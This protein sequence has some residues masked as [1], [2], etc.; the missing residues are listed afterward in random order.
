[1]VTYSAYIG[2]RLFLQ[3]RIE[4]NKRQA[5]IFI[6]SNAGIEELADTLISAGIIKN[7]D[8]FRTHAAIH[9]FRTVMG[10]H[11]IVK[12]N[13][14]YRNLVRMLISGQQ[15]P[16]N[17]VISGTVRTKERLA[18]IISRQIEADSVE[19][20]DL[21]NDS[22]FLNELGFTPDNSIL[23][24]I[25]NTYNVYWNRNI[26]QLFRDMKKEFDRFWSPERLAKLNS[27]N[28]T[29]IEA[30]IVASISSEESN[31]YD[32]LPCIAGVYIN[33]LRIGMPLQAD[34]TVKFA[35][36]D[37]SLRRILTVHTEFDSPYNTYRHRGLPPGPI[38]IPSP[39]AIDAVLDCERHN[40]LYFCAKDDFSGYHVFAK[41][42]QQHNQNASLY[43][44][45][46][47]RRKIY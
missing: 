30:M 10:G 39:V 38:C 4:L 9:G 5:S 32:E 40:Y 26:R 18:K 27:L 33:R 24:F 19:V 31:K 22:V 44:K 28:L 15:T 29:K 6:P 43:G 45:A 12:K 8:R 23:L 34:P 47:N 13:M 36:G 35:I 14:T 25:P 7:S 20:T 1:M 42:L 21:L 3:D 46:L 17:L 2:Y 37:F 16:V 41:T 11:Y